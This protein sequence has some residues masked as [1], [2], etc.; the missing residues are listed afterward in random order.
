MTISKHHSTPVY[1]ASKNR[2]SRY[3]NSGSRQP[4]EECAYVQ[5]ESRGSDVGRRRMQSGTRLLP[6]V[7]RGDKV[8]HPAGPT[9]RLCSAHLDEWRA[10]DAANGVELK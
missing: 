5:H 10:R 1:K 9:L 2:P 7:K 4:C 8:I 3:R 6:E